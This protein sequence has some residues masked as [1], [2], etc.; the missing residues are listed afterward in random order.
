MKGLILFVRDFPC[1][2]QIEKCFLILKEA[3]L[4]NK[5]NVKIN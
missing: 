1:L 2:E 3:L 4:K 5:E